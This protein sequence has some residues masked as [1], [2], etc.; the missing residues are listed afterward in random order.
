LANA[1]PIAETTDSRNLADLD[2]DRFLDR[3]RSYLESS[4]IDD[5]LLRKEIDELL[6]M[7]PNRVGKQTLANP[8]Q[9]PACDYL[10]EAIALGQVTPTATLLDALMTL[11][12]RLR[13][14]YEYPPDARWPLLPSRV[15]FAQIVGARGLRDD[16]A[17]QLGLTLIAPETH[18]PLHKHP[19]IETYLVLAGAASWRT[20][21]RSFALR[22]PGSLILHESD[23]GHAME[24]RD[25]PLLALYT[26]RGDLITAPTYVDE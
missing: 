15:A 26:W 3:T 19:A 23:I 20:V 11:I 12:P 9:L 16:A 21:G 22:D 24:T 25:E 17:V 14:T 13:W 7:W 4:E 1:G 10:Q 8:S 2:L 6:A 18:Y 5:V